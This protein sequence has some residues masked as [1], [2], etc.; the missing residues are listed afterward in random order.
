LGGWLLVWGDGVVDG[1][2][3]FAYA[4]GGF[5]LDLSDLRVGQLWLLPMIVFF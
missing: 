4:D 1:V 2:E 5:E 3:L